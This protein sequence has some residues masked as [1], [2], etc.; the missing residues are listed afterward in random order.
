M[1]HKRKTLLFALSIFIS[2]TILF[3]LTLWSQ[4]S[5]DFL[6][7]DFMGDVD[8]ELRIHSFNPATIHDI[9]SW[10]ENQSEVLSADEYYYNSA[11]FNAVD[12]D[13][14]YSFLPYESQLDQER[15]VFLSSLLLPTQEALEHIDHQFT[16]D[17]DFSLEENEVLLSTSQA[18]QLSV[19]TNQTIVPGMQ[20][21][22]SICRNS[23]EIGYHTIL[24]AYQPLHF[25][26]ITVRG[27]YQ[28]IPSSTTLQEAFAHNYLYNS[29]IFLRDNLDGSD[30][31]LM[32][33]NGLYPIILSKLTN[34]FMSQNG[35]DGLYS[36][37]V[38][39][40]DILTTRNP[41][42][43]AYLLEEPFTEL[44]LAFHQANLYF[45]ILIPIITLGL[46]SSLIVSNLIIAE[47]KNS[48]KTL[49]A[50][51]AGRNQIISLLSTEF[52][53]I[54]LFV[55]LISLLCSFLFAALIPTLS[56][57]NSSF[58]VFTTFL[59]VLK[60]PFLSY[61]ITLAIFIFTTILFVVLRTNHSIN[62]VL[63]ERQ[64][65]ERVKFLFNISLISGI[66]L[67]LSLLG[68]MIY[69]S[70]IFSQEIA[71]VSP[72]SLSHV[73]DSAFLFALFL[74]FSQC[75]LILLSI[76]IVFLLSKSKKIF[77]KLFPHT[78]FF[79]VQ[80]FKSN[81]NEIGVI[82]LLA[83]VF[84]SSSITNLTIANSLNNN[85]QQT[86]FYNEGADLRIHTNETDYQFSKTLRN[87]EEITEAMPIF[88]LSGKVLYRAITIYGVNPDK[89]ARI[90]RWH[91][92]S[93]NE[94][95]YPSSYQN[96]N[97]SELLHQLTLQPYGIIIS[98]GL[99]DIY[100]YNIGDL[101]KI[102]DI[103][104]LYGQGDSS[105]LIVG[106]LHSAPGF[107]LSTDTNSDFVFIHEIRMITD[108]QLLNVKLFFA[109]KEPDYTLSEV[110][111]KLMSSS[112]ITKV[113]PAISVDS[114][115]RDYV[116]K[117]LPDI[118]FYLYL[119]TILVI[120]LSS[121]LIVGCLNFSLHKRK[122]AESIYFA[123][124]NTFKNLYKELLIELVFILFLSILFGLSI[125]FLL[126]YLALTITP[127]F[128]MDQIIIPIGI[129]IKPVY[130]LFLIPLLSI[131]TL[132]TL[133]PFLFTMQRKQI[134]TLLKK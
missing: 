88:E 119:E 39:F 114:T 131:T 104:T 32:E 82:L 7:D 128:F 103:Q 5:E 95:Y 123:L 118:H 56:S 122:F 26:N 34:E 42:I 15:P 21:N 61:F 44:S 130:I 65:K 13:P 117:Y 115:I 8:Y 98:E 54:I 124:G 46:L 29:V 68:Y 60:F 19:A 62:Q 111:E 2:M 58:E 87:Y 11:L 49:A 48:I 91:P 93:F 35:I 40:R 121:S 38:Y 113:N 22:L 43:F 28:V 66:V 120:L 14:F 100:N 125:G 64:K 85:E 50:R 59:A 10:L 30:I 105:F 63:E 80:N 126:V 25:Y 102:R 96:M 36:Q 1:N 20:I 41:S 23:P 81:R 27:I 72:Y 33:D 107:G 78:G 108:Y 101:I 127:P 94:K 69:R 109:S 73:K 106:I 4:S 133:Q 90:A 47:R 16:V 75:F 18:Q 112:I 84:F 45:I 129:D 70:I 9:T 83:M 99:A 74:I 31:E 77:R 53:L 116:A 51:N 3:S 92:S 110:T 12:K 132:L 24:L 86:I 37:A 17:G 71:Y 89:F 52:T 55:S 76:G 57:G 134:V 6:I 67:T 97:T 79:L